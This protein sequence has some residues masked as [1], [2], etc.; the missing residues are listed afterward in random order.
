M[1]E[2]DGY[3]PGVP[4]WVSAVERDPEAAASFYGRLFGWELES[5]MPSDSAGAYILCRLRGRDVAAVVSTDGAP[6]PPAS[7]WTTHVWV[8]SAQ[9]TAAAVER[10]GG[11]ILGSPFHSPGG[12]RMAVLADP[13]GAVFS[14]WEPV[15]R[16]G[17]QLVNEPG[18]WA[19]SQL[20]TDDIERAEQ[21][22]GEV[23]G[24]E[25]DELD[26]GAALVK[27]WRVPGYVGGEPQQPVSREVVAV[28]IELGEQEAAA[29]AR[30]GWNPDFWVADIDATATRAAELGGSVVVATHEIPMFKRAVLSDPEGASFSASQLVLP[31]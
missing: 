17:A 5:L 24:W 13:S 31:G 12:G 2:R 10:A 21:F 15:E 16:R 6:P 22:Y 18:A 4:C 20:L 23:F 11:S 28:V 26:A 14:V 7:V 29:G 1:S 27:L 3:A 8:D 30:P 25:A 19:M 9:D